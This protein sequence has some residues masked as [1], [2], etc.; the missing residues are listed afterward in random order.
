MIRF[1]VPMLV[2]LV[3]GMVLADEDKKEEKPTEKVETLTI[4]QAWLR[5][6]KDAQATAAAMKKVKG[7][8]FKEAEI[9]QA[10]FKRW[11]KK[12][13]LTGTVAEVVSS[14]P[15]RIDPGKISR[16]QGVTVVMIGKLDL[17]LPEDKLHAQIIESNLALFDFVDENPDHPKAKRLNRGDKITIEATPRAYPQQLRPPFPEPVR[18]RFTESHIVD[19]GVDKKKKRQQKEE[20]ASNK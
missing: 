5:I 12:I 17:S 15:N 4:E 6:R 3:P 1:L 13:R 7:N 9:K 10:L 19:D 11:D 16:E 20:K 18:W 2:V 8:E 14:I